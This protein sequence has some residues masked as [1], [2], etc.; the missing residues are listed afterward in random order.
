MKS[1]SAYT[2]EIDDLEAAAEELTEKVSELSLK[3]NTVGIFYADV[4]TDF[5]ELYDNLRQKVS[6]PIVGVSA[7]AMLQSN[8]GYATTGIT[9]LVL[10]ADDCEF[11]IGISEDIT[12]ENLTEQ[13]RETYRKTAK[14]QSEKEKLIML[15]ATKVLTK[16][17]DDFSEILTEESGGVPIYGAMA[18]DALTF[19]R[20][21]VFYNGE[22]KTAGAVI[23]LISGNI[24]PLFRYEFSVSEETALRDEVCG[25]TEGL[26]S[27]MGEKGF[28]SAL[29]E[30]GLSS[31]KTDVIVDYIT[32]PFIATVKTEDGEKVRVLRNLTRLFHDTDKG[33]FLGGIPEG[34]T[35]SVSLVNRDDVQKSIEKALEKITKSIRQHTEYEYST[36]LCSSCSARYLALGTN[37]AA[38]G[39]A[40]EDKIPNNME[41]AGI[42]SYG[43]FCPAQG[44]KTDKQY[45]VFQ[46]STFTIM[47]I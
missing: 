45:N 7:L 22:E 24:K 16:Q 19:D 38:E 12:K 23:I 15:F 28:V 27:K 34:S 18:S 13:V 4:D 46:N 35:L 33:M 17:G 47:A 8:V 31:D 32:S 44:E 10:T 42:Y 26:V 1:I 5:Q 43:E 37:A 41:L 14:R 30:V 3:K 40:F 11:T 25:S 2:E 36:L 6:Y 29:E 39:K 20:Y 9:F 21:R